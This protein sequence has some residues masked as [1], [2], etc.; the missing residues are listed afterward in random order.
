MLDSL[1][2][3]AQAHEQPIRD[4]RANYADFER[5]WRELLAVLEARLQDA[6]KE[7]K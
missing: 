5:R 6:K 1:P 4:F 2:A 7:V 3:F